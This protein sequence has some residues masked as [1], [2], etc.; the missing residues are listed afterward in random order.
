MYIFHVN[1]CIQNL[2]E[3]EKKWTKQRATT[4]NEYKQRWLPSKYTRISK[5]FE[6]EIQ[7]QNTNKIQCVFLSSSSSS[8]ECEKEQKMLVFF[9]LRPINRKSINSVFSI[10]C[11]NYSKEENLY[12]MDWKLEEER[13]FVRMHTIV[14]VWVLLPLLPNG[15]TL[16]WSEWH[17]Y[18][19]EQRST[20]K[21]FAMKWRKKMKNEDD[22]CDESHIKC[23]TYRKIIIVIMFVC[24]L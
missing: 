11:W 10:E 21:S 8:A 7:R 6:G 19:R 16:N 24:S 22:A 17:E 2:D 12:A 23:S 3:N 4:H 9:C 15:H 5:R 20:Q 14:D 18:V 13:K 1:V